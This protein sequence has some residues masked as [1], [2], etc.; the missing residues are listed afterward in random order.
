MTSCAPTLT[1]CSV[2]EVT[3]SVITT[4]TVVPT[5]TNTAVSGPGSGVGG[6]NKAETTTILSVTTATEKQTHTNSATLESDAGDFNN[7]TAA[8]P[9]FYTYKASVS[10]S[11]ISGVAQ[12]TGKTANSRTSA[13]VT[14]SSSPTEANNSASPV[15]SKAPIVASGAARTGAASLV[16]ALVAVVWALTL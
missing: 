12:A 11:G 16:L 13:M 14:T 4:T 3:S 15:S 2:D 9:G 10:E 6:Q 1:D 7:K 8:G 5:T